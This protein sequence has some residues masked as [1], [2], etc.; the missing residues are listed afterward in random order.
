MDIGPLLPGRV[1]NSLVGSRLTSTLLANQSLLQKLQDQIATGQKFFLPSESPA[2]A[3]RTIT[4]QGLIER[5]DQALTNIQSSRN[6]LSL[7][8]QSLTSVSEAL[9]RAKG[10]VL[11]ASDTQLS[12]AEQESLATELDSLIRQV[13]TAGN[14]QYSG[15]VLFGGTS[16]QS[17]FEVLPSGFV[18]FNG[19]TGSIN[20]LID[21][22]QLQAN[23]VSANT[24]FGTTSSPVSSDVNPALT[25]ST[26][27]SDLAGGSGIF[28]S[29][30]KITLDNGG[31]PQVQTID[32]TGAS[33]IQ[34][35]KTRIEDAFS[36][37]PLTIGVAINPAKNGLLFTPSAG[38]VQV[39]EVN[40]GTI[41][42]ELGVLSA[43]AATITGG[44]LDPRITLQTKLS[45][46]NGGAG[47]TAT[48][49][50]GLRI[51][52]GGTTT[53]VDVSGAVTVEDLFNKLQ[54]ADLSL[55]TRINDAGN[56][57]SITTRL[58]G[59]DF[60][61]GENG[62]TTAAD[63]GIRTFKTSTLLSSLNHG[64]GVPLSSG[65]KLQIT[66]RDGTNAEVD[67]TGSTTIQDVISK[68]NLVDPG[69]LVASFKTVGNGIQITDNSGTGPLSISKNEISEALGLDGSETSNVNTNPLSGRDVNP[70]ET[71]GTLNALVRLRDAIRS[72][73][74]TQLSRLDTQIDDSINNVTFARGEVGIRLKDLDNLEEQINNEKLQFQSSLSQDFEVD[75]AEVI[76]QLATKQTTYEATLKISS[77]LLQLSLVQF[78]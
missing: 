48:A 29:S 57:L 59:S 56:G 45:D 9:N 61:I 49:A 69:N 62:E 67:L 63:L 75:L 78:L 58:A 51:T 44:D 10:I 42:A 18:R 31:T 65:V 20:S 23:N 7:S 3:L 76:S 41:A 55:D 37:G 25:L 73:D 22:R 21:L 40:G 8:D 74:R 19:N 50:G 11:Q 17:P 54:A 16:N 27:L 24:P 77:Q 68:I 12:P 32:L 15:R 6:L 38:T 53:V 33:T 4:L 43:A 70:Q 13:V 30:L 46:L 52:N 35:I 64:N 5:K 34:D 26:R 14:S 1:P 72:G 47:I 36:G 66:R 39:E 60:S 28:P 2:A 71:Y